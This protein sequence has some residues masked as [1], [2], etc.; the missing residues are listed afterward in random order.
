MRGTM[1]LC[2]QREGPPKTP[3][4]WTRNV[5]FT[6]TY[7]KSGPFWFPTSTE[8]VTEVRIFGSTSLTIHYFD[9]TPTPL[10]A[11]LSAS[12]ELRQGIA[13]VSGSA[14]GVSHGGKACKQSMNV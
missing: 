10:Q 2:A 6:H 13:H 3:R 7:Q 8:S 4:S 1:L 5:Q 9:Y 14:I 12:A 11:P